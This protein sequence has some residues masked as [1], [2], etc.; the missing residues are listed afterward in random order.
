MSDSVPASSRTPSISSDVRAAMS[1]SS[2]MS[3][4]TSS[5]RSSIVIIPAVPP[6]SSITTAMYARVR[7][8]SSSTRSAALLSGTY[9]ASRI[10]SVSLNGVPGSRSQRS[11][12]RKTPTMS[13]SVSRYNGYREYRS[14]RR[15]CS[16]SS[17]VEPI[18]IATTSVRGRITSCARFCLKSKTPASI[19]RS[20]SSSSPCACACIT[21]VLSSSGECAGTSFSTTALIPNARATTLA[22]ALTT[23]TNGVRTSPINRTTGTAYFRAMSGCSLA[24]ARGTSSPTTI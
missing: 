4:I 20:D 19:A 5:T 12:A 18:S 10:S 1:Y 2:V 13:S 23:M 6:Y 7:R 11:F 15:T 17:S 9:K 16:T 24:T 8:R 22:I 21:S 3:P 14:V